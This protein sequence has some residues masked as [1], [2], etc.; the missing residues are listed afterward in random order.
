MKNQQFL[1]EDIERIRPVSTVTTDITWSTAESCGDKSDLMFSLSDISRKI[2]A[3]GMA[4]ETEKV[5][6]SPPQETL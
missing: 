2:A 6:T 1:Q 4:R 5:D 3:M